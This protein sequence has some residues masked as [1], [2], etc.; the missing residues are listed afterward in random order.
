[1]PGED[2]APSGGAS[3]AVSRSFVRAL[4]YGRVE[5]IGLVER[6]PMKTFLQHAGPEP[7]K[8]VGDF[9]R[10][11]RPSAEDALADKPIF[12]LD[13]PRWQAFRNLLDRPAAVKPRLQRLLADDSVPE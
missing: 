5:S 13:E 11:T 8:H 7:Q 4:S 2:M 6:R 10:K 1:M 12:R 3:R 9:L